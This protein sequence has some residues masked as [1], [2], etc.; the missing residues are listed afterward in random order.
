M[1]KTLLSLAF[2]LIAIQAEAGVGTTSS[3]RVAPSVVNAVSSNLI[4]RGFAVNDPRFGP[5]ARSIAGS[6]AAIGLG[7]SGLLGG[8]ALGA[9]L[10]AASALAIGGGIYL[11][12][13][14][15]GYCELKVPADEPAPVPKRPNDLLVPYNPGGGA[16]PVSY[17]HPESMR[18]CVETSAFTSCV[19]PTD[20]TTYAAQLT[21]QCI[22]QLQVLTDKASGTTTYNTSGYTQTFPAIYRSDNT[23]PIFEGD[24]LGGNRPGIANPDVNQPTIYGVST[25]QNPGDFLTP[26]QL[27][28][29]ASDEIIARMADAAYALAS[30]SAQQATAGSTQQPI[31]PRNPY[32]PVLPSTGQNASSPDPVTIRDLFA[33]PAT[34]GNIADVPQSSQNPLIGPLVDAQ[35]ATGFGGSAS[36]PNPAQPTVDLGPDPGIPLNP[37]TAGQPSELMAPFLELLIPAKSIEFPNA[38]EVACQPI[39]FSIPMFNDSF[40]MSFHCVFFDNYG[41]FLQNLMLFAYAIT[42]L[43]IVLGA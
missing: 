39:T 18:S 19:S 5:T 11:I 42:A 23:N 8:L 14:A 24:G 27:D 43:L 12:C 29:P 31:I 4:S 38:S 26:A 17:E 1:K 9:G 34:T 22:S 3:T 6:I 32:S 10:G 37:I 21:I 36:E 7:G 28:T 33:T 41:S 16:S 2:A 30:Q 13:L 20:C 25:G 15:S 35:P 40:S